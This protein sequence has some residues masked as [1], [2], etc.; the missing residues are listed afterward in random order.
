MASKKKDPAWKYGVEIEHN[1]P[2]GVGKKGYK[3]IQCN[4]C[5]KTIKGGVKRM[6][7]HLACT[8]K[9]VAPCEHV[10]QKVKDEITLYLKQF[11][12]NKISSQSYFEENV[13]SG[14]YY[15]PTNNSGTGSRG[16]RGPMDRFVNEPNDNGPEAT[17]PNAKEQRKQVCMDIG[18][19]FFENGIPFNVA[20]SPSFTNMLRSVGNFGR[21]FKP[22]SMHELRTWILDEEVKTTNAMVD[23]IKAT[24]KKT[25]V[26]LLSDGWSDMRNRSLINFLVNNQYGTVFLKTVD[27]SDCIKNAQK[28]FEL[29]DEVVEEIGEDIVVQVVTDNA[30]AYKAAGNLLMKKRPSLYW[31]PCAAH[32]IDLMLE[33]IGE[34]PQH[35]NALLKAKKI[36]NFIY[37]HQWVLSLA[38]KMLKKDLLR[39]AATRFATAFLTVQSVYELKAR[40]QQMFVSNEWR[41]CDWSKKSDGK[42]VK[43]IV[44]DDTYFWPSVVYSIKTTMP[45]VEVLRLVDGEKTPA[46]GFIYG[47]MDECKE[48]IAK[49]FNSDVSFYK[50]I[51]EIID[52]KWDF[53]MHRD[54]HAA[55]YYL[56]PRYRWSPN[57]SEHAEIKRGLYGVLNRLVKDTNVFMKIEDQLIEYKEKQG[58]FGYKGSLLS[59]KTRPPVQWW[60]QYGDDTPELKAFALK[61]IGL[62]C[63]ASACERNWSTFNQVHTKRR[64]R[65]GTKRMN[66]LVYI[67][68]NR[69]L[70]QKFMKKK[71]E[72]EDPLCIENVMSDDEWLIGESSET[73][74]E[75]DGGGR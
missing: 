47:A 19:F 29:L 73:H 65:L 71:N 12:D 50:E 67:M 10:P 3:Y 17:S 74:A 22:P 58:L 60:D 57:V 11:K 1:V 9:D 4:F 6:K 64:N 32:C 14:A 51:W 55:A 70:K 24:W 48:K 61:V 40:L 15:N 30:S 23:D 72:E 66:D 16:M 13:G 35:K 52:N 54:L 49:N 26:S 39:P 56:N 28:I 42:E 7:E 38:R 37:N 8:H 68:Y 69:K 63:S 5:G 20:T 43:K 36:S 44:M 27:A 2:E 33:K 45:L 34:L 41:D 31:T 21:G 25:G 59:Y 53:Q 75:E 62:T 46:M 18:R